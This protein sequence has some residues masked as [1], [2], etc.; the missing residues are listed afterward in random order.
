MEEDLD[1]NKPQVEH[2]KP[3]KCKIRINLGS[4][5]R[6]HMVKLSLDVDDELQPTRISRTLDVE[7][8]HLVM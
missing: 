2:P 4:K 5:R 7:D 1:E 6:A 3:N 8:N